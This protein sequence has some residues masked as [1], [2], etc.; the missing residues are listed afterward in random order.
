MAEASNLTI[1][2]SDSNSHTEPNRRTL[3]YWACGFIVLAVG[4]YFLVKH[5]RSGW[6]VD[7]RDADAHQL[8]GG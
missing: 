8:Q 7:S 5:H 1:D 3:I 6:Q 4:V 2:G